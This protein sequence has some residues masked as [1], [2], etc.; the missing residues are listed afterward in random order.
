MHII[1]ECLLLQYFSCK[2]S[3][4]SDTII[5]HSRGTDYTFST[6]L[7]CNNIFQVKRTSVPLKDLKI[8]GKTYRE[9]MCTCNMKGES[10]CNI[11]LQEVKKS[12]ADTGHHRIHSKPNH[13]KKRHSFVITS[14]DSDSDDDRYATVPKPTNTGQAHMSSHSHKRRHSTKS[15]SLSPRMTRPSP[16]LLDSSLA[17]EDD[18][19]ETYKAITRT[20]T[21]PIGS[22]RKSVMF[23]V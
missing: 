18:V 6:Y 2:H 16:G 14:V 21:K 12:L 4:V 23:A 15:Q 3:S 11:H 10:Q 9:V 5:A 1:L 19:T 22:K 8:P 17:A 20:K 13:L 7:I